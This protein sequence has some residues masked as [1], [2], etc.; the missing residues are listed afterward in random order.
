[1]Q[2]SRIIIFLVMGQN[3]MSRCCTI[4][5]NNISSN[6]TVCMHLTNAHPNRLPLV[7][8]IGMALKNNHFKTV[9]YIYS[10]KVIKVPEICVGKSSQ[11]IQFDLNPKNGFGWHAGVRTPW[12]FK[13]HYNNTATQKLPYCKLHSR[14]QYRLIYYK[15]EEPVVNNHIVLELALLPFNHAHPSRHETLS[16]KQ[17]ISVTAQI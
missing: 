15:L 17:I 4:W 2:I 10:Q 8:G 16:N 11:D 12:S 5:S 3:I 9:E 7:E 6:L 13:G 1:M 14:P